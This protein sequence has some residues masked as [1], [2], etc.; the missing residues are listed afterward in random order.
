MYDYWK[1]KIYLEL[2]KDSD[3]ILNLASNEYSK[4]VTKYLAPDIR[5]V[6]CI[7]GELIDGK[8]KEKGVYVKMARGEIVRYMVENSIED[9][10]QI[11]GFDRLRFTYSDGLSKADK[12]VFLK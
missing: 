4:T 9:I 11:K 3:V 1:D 8:V 5:F 12:Y 6:N 2:T 10:E 7:F